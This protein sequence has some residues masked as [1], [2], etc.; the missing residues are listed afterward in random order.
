MHNSYKRLKYTEARK[1]L[2]NVDK[3]SFHKRGSRRAYTPYGIF[4]LYSNK[5]RKRMFSVKN[6]EYFHNGG[7]YTFGSLKIRLLSV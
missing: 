5:N 3:L 6:S 4:T 1:A 2:A 7:N